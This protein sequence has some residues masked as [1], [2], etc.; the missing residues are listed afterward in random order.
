[1]KGAGKD[2]VAQSNDNTAEIN[3]ENKL[4]RALEK[5][6]SGPQQGAVDSAWP[7][8][9]HEDRFVR[10]AARIAVEHQPLSEW[11]ATCVKRDRSATLT[12]AI[13]ALARHGKQDLKN[14]LLQALMKVNYAKLS[15]EQQIDLLR[16]FEVIFFRMGNPEGAVKNQVVAYLDAHYPGQGK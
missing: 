2:D 4:R 5:F 8:L 15:P 11:Q 14:S 10:Y 12:Q 6:H 13:I 7:N 16:A 9:K 3:E 1:M